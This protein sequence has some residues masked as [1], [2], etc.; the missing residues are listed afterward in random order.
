MK[1]KVKI[2][3]KSDNSET[4]VE[5]TPKQYKQYF[6]SKY[7]KVKKPKKKRLKKSF[8]DVKTGRAI[9]GIKNMNAEFR[10]KMMLDD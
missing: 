8:T 5:M 6:S 7:G 3:K 4:E 10:R 2:V 1:I 9:G